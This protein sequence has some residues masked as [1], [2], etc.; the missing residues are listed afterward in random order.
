[1]FTH[2]DNQL[3]I[4]KVFVFD[5]Y[6]E[7]QD[8]VEQR[9]GVQIDRE[10]RLWKTEY[11]GEELSTEAKIHFESLHHQSIDLYHRFV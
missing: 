8:F 10:R 11:T 5:R 4:D 6:H 9:F 3:C 1:M 2:I 7:A